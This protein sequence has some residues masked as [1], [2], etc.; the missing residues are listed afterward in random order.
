MDHGWKESPQATVHSSTFTP[1]ER[2]RKW[3]GRKKSKRVCTG[4]KKKLPS[5]VVCI[6]FMN[7][8]Y[9]YKYLNCR[10]TLI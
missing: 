10:E 2:A 1:A 7:K 6:L 8:Y 9:I 3:E 5:P 4:K